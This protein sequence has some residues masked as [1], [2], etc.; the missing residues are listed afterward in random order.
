MTFIGIDIL[1]QSNES[2]KFEIDSESKIDITSFYE[3]I[4][5]NYLSDDK[6]LQIKILKQTK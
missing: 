3:L 5:Y 1:F 4:D 6:L 2:N